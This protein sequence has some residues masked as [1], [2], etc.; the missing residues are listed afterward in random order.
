MKK[1]LLI[2]FVLLILIPCV[3]AQAPPFQES[4]PEAAEM[5]V[6]VPKVEYIL[7][8]ATFLFYAHVY[9]SS[10][11]LMTNTTTDCYIHVYNN[12]GHHTLEATMDFDSNLM[13]WNYTLNSTFTIDKGYLPYIV[14]CNDT[15]SGGFF[16]G[17]LEIND[18]TSAGI[19][20]DTT[21]SISLTLFILFAT[22]LIFFLPR[23]YGT[24]TSNEMVNLLITRCFYIIG[25]YLM[26]MNA[27]IFATIADSAG[28]ATSEIFRY[29]WIFGKFGYLLLFVV[30]IKTIFDLVEL[31][32]KAVMQKRGLD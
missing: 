22:I 24:F 8:D 21:H 25:I 32:K 1:T 31:N 27:G 9:N 29:M 3:I 28:Y 2:I 19:T 20:D 12:T 11:V 23:M 17:T 30:A 14:W 4:T 26:V 5:S 6:I 16:S 18:Q 15:R 13:E 10:G 7:E